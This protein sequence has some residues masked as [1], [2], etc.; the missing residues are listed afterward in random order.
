MNY[1]TNELEYLLKTLTDLKIDIKFIS[2]FNTIGAILTIDNRSNIEIK[3]I[4]K[5]F[6]DLS[7]HNL[8]NARIGVIKDIIKQIRSFN[9]IY[10]PK[11][12]EAK[13]LMLDYMHQ[14]QA[15]YESQFIKGELVLLTNPDANIYHKDWKDWDVEII[16]DQCFKIC[17][18]QTLHNNFSEIIGGSSI[19]NIKDILKKECTQICEIR[20]TSLKDAHDMFE[21]YHNEDKEIS[22]ETEWHSEKETPFTDKDLEELGFEHYMG[23]DYDKVFPDKKIMVRLLYKSHLNLDNFPE[24]RV[25]GGLIFV[26]NFNENSYKMKLNYE[27]EIKSQK[28]LCEL[29]N[30][31]GK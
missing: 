21:D 2:G 29:L 23:T 20:A 25:V 9:N 5:E 15:H 12:I 22:V 18:N 14:L 6:A 1:Y 24:L 7:L 16:A 19:P 26:H 17:F 31:Y 27:G 28:H 11:Y 10:P 13:N 4:N 3:Q 8:E 30:E